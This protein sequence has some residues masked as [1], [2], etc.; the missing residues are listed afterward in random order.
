MHPTPIDCPGGRIYGDGNAGYN[1]C[2]LHEGRP[3]GAVDGSATDGDPIMTLDLQ[4]G[5]VLV[6]SDVDPV[7]TVSL[8][9]GDPDVP[10]SPRPRVDLDDDAPDPGN[11]MWQMQSPLMSC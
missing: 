6:K 8:A 11:W 1:L 5:S 3:A 4:S 7:Y 9:I 10:E 2:S